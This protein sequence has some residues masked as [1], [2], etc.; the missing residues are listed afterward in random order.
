VDVEDC[1]GE[2]ALH[3][4]A[5]NGHLSVAQLLIS[6]GSDINK[7]SKWSSSTPLHLSCYEG[8]HTLVELLISHGA[9]VNARDDVNNTPLDLT[10]KDSDVYQMLIT[11][12]AELGP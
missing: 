7:R 9:D 5:E 1:F 4:A 6:Q 2:T 8:H 11:H 10:S 3:Q 12:G